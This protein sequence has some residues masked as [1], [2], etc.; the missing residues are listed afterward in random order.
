MNKTAKEATI[1]IDNVDYVIE[2]VP[3]T[4]KFQIANI[5]FCDIKISSLQNELAISNTARSGY[6]IAFQAE[7]EQRTGADGNTQ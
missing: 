6:L 3:E 7:C 1:T 5:K 2:N 4:A